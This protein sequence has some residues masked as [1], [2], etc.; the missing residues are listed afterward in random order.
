MLFH[1]VPSFS[2][3]LLGCYW[4]VDVH[5]GG[6]EQNPHEL[7]IFLFNVSTSISSTLAAKTST[8]NC[9]QSFSVGSIHIPLTPP[10]LLPT[11]MPHALVMCARRYANSWH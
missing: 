9:C 8:S 1:F 4:Y 3:S 10:S 5:R 7:V 2:P 6:L 11:N